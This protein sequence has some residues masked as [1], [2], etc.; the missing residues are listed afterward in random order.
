MLMGGIVPYSHANYVERMARRASATA[1]VCLLLAGMIGCGS[2]GD[3]G[4]GNPKR[5]LRQWY[6]GVEESVA[7]MERKQRGFTRF[8]VS[9]P[10]EESEIVALSPAGARAG[11]TAAGAARQLDAATALTAEEAAGLYCYFFAF[12]VD[13]EFF[14]DKEEFEVVI[15]NLVKTRLSPSASS[16][17]VRDSAAG[18]RKAMVA[19]ENA[20][21]PGGEVAAAILC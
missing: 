21:V 20:G 15:H 12:Y 14:P 10:P 18:L 2:G 19:A 16:A 5:E 7:A 6:S 3:G 17:E 13:L 11:E 4:G 9:E 1:V 8:R